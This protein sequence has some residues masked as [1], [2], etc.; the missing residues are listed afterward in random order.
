[1]EKT[2]YMSPVRVTTYVKLGL[3]VSRERVLRRE[4]TIAEVATLG[5]LVMFLQEGVRHTVL[6][7]DGQRWLAIKTF[8]VIHMTDRE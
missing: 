1:M 6:V 5:H 4:R 3:Q 8:H 7:H 2:P